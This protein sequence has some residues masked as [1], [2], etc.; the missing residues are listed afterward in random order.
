MDDGHDDHDLCSTPL[1]ESCDA[2]TRRALKNNGYVQNK[3]SGKITC[4]KKHIENL[5]RLKIEAGTKGLHIKDE[6]RLNCNDCN[7]DD[8]YGC[9]RTWVMP[10][11]ITNLIIEN[12]NIKYKLVEIPKIIYTISTLTYLNIENNAI[13][14][15]PDEIICLNQLTHFIFTNNPIVYISHNIKHLKEL[16]SLRM[17]VEYINVIPNDVYELELFNLC[18]CDNHH[19]TDNDS[20]DGLYIHYY[21]DDNNNNDDIITTK[22]IDYY[23]N[24]INTVFKAIVMGRDGSLC[25]EFVQWYTKQSYHNINVTLNTKKCS[26][27]SNNNSTISL[28]L[29]MNL[30]NLG[31]AAYR[32]IFKDQY[33]TTS[34]FFIVCDMNMRCN[35]FEANLDRYI[36]LIV[37]RCQGSD[38]EI[39]VIGINGDDKHRYKE[40]IRNF[41]YDWIKFYALLLIDDDMNFVLDDDDD[42]QYNECTKNLELNNLRKHIVHLSTPTSIQ[43]TPFFVNKYLSS[44]I[45]NEINDLNESDDWLFISSVDTK[46]T[47]ESIQMLVIR[48]DVIYNKASM[49]IFNPRYYLEDVRSYFKKVCEGIATHSIDQ[50]EMPVYIRDRAF[51]VETLNL[52]HIDDKYTY[53][54]DLLDYENILVRL[55]IDTSTIISIPDSRHDHSL[56]YLVCDLLPLDRKIVTVGSDEYFIRLER[57]YHFGKTDTIA[58]PSYD[59]I[60]KLYAN[61]YYSNN[62]KTALC[63]KKAMEQIFETETG[64]EIKIVVEYVDSDRKNHILKLNG[65][66]YIFNTNEII[67]ILDEFSQSLSLL[68]NELPAYITPC[69]HCLAIGYDNPG[70]FTLDVIKKL[71][72]QTHM[73]SDIICNRGCSVPIDHIIDISKL[74]VSNMDQ[75]LDS[76]VQ[77]LMDEIIIKASTDSTKLQRSVVRLRLGYALNSDIDTMTKI[78]LKKPHKLLKRF[79]FHP[80]SYASG[81]IVKLDDDRKFIVSSQ[82][83]I[84][85]LVNSVEGVLGLIGNETEFF[86]TCKPIIIGSEYHQNWDLACFELITPVSPISLTKICRHEVIVT[87]QDTPVHVDSI[88][89]TDNPT[90]SD[91]ELLRLLAYPYIKKYQYYHDNDTTNNTISTNDLLFTIDWG[92]CYS[93]ELEINGK[94]IVN[95]TTNRGASGGPVL[96]KDGILVGIVKGVHET[97]AIGAYVEPTRNLKEILSNIMLK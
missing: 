93:S 79:K 4:F 23:D 61:N 15:I 84:P 56:L 51:I 58:P 32:G 74:D 42:D 16:R 24:N 20:N 19:S 70:I 88:A 62:T 17:A 63:S 10:V 18:C 75:E 11:W 38:V 65:Y 81:I 67:R 39:I 30:L 89:I 49:V 13:T 59:T 28:D 55:L 5:S 29:K 36:R 68:C 25:D 64:G 45:V 44:T 96:N 6:D 78:A 86:Y 85:S 82:H 9:K 60:Y 27:A 40:Y 87:L 66:G 7:D 41:K 31:D 35:D 95:F 37:N 14:T 80:K 97:L 72:L 57:Q 8:C 26:R 22:R 1:L 3:S 76:K 52:H 47:P 90:V 54:E 92:R 46:F 21:N 33:N 43:P 69:P 73:K 91:N 94:Y 12:P 77:F 83:A 71:A 48:G 34:L 50:T 2:M 53:N